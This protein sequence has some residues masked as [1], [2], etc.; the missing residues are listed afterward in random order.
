M[1]RVI[2]NAQPPKRGAVF[3]PPLLGK[4]PLMF[5]DPQSLR[6]LGTWPDLRARVVDV[7]GREACTALLNVP[8]AESAAAQPV[9]VLGDLLFPLG[10]P[11]PHFFPGGVHTAPDPTDTQALKDWLLRKGPKGDARVIVGWSEYGVFD[12][13]WA[14]A[15]RWLIGAGEELLIVAPDLSWACLDAYS[16][17]IS[18]GRPELG[19][20]DRILFVERVRAGVG[21]GT[22]LTPKPRYVVHFADGQRWASE[23]LADA[24]SRPMYDAVLGHLAAITGKQVTRCELEPEERAAKR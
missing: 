22:R 13:T 16:E 21:N 2:C 15:V 14:N 11:A 8:A 18:L 24:A 20:V 1:R 4:L 6:P 23:T 5:L 9:W 3:P 17:S 10:T 19:A 7:L 12:T